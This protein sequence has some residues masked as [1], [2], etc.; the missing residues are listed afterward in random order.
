MNTDNEKISDTDNEKIGGANNEQ[1][2]SS[3]EKYMIYNIQ[4]NKIN[5][6][7]NN[8]DKSDMNKSSNVSSDVR[9]RRQNNN[10]SWGK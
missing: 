2:S 5:T 7:N 9:Y 1:I 10:S 4:T 3:S 8:V 6:S